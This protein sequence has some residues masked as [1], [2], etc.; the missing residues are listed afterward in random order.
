MPSTLLAA[1]E[2]PVPVQQQTTACSA[3]PSATSR[4]AASLAHAQSSPLLLAERAVPH[5]LVPPPLQLRDDRLRHTDRSSAATL[6]FMAPS[7]RP[8]GQLS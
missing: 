2:A 8:R 6:I 5:R 7:L 4:A 1:I 3:R